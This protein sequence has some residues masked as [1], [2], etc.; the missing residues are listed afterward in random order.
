M[1]SHQARRR[2]SAAAKR[3]VEVGSLSADF[4]IRPSQTRAAALVSAGGLWQR[5]LMCEVGRGA[6]DFTGP[7]AHFYSRL[8]S[9]S[10]FHSL[11]SL[12]LIF[13]GKMQGLVSFV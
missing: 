7:Q 1:S 12:I 4:N 10:I 11:Y 2:A 8:Y 6:A 5:F 9:H 13:N 3:S